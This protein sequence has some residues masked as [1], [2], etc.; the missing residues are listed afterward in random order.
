MSMQVTRHGFTVIGGKH[1]LRCPVA[2]AMT[3]SGGREFAA[4]VPVLLPVDERVAAIGY[5]YG[6]RTRPVRWSG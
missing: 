4:C 6:E 1:T 3:G 2:P 5:P